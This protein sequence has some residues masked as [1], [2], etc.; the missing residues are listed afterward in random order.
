MSKLKGNG[1]E[2]FFHLL[3]SPF[4][5]CHL[6]SSPLIFYCFFWCA[7]FLLCLLFAVLHPFFCSFKKIIICCSFF[8]RSI[9]LFLRIL[10]VIYS[11]LVCSLL[12]VPSSSVLRQFFIRYSYVVGLFLGCLG[13]FFIH[14]SFTLCLFFV[15]SLNP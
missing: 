13:L 5:S 12:L 3:S 10:H 8:V 15:L 11:F 14:S 2:V 1:C 4:I 6:L 9:F 7:L